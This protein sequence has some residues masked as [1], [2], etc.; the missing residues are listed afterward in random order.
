MPLSSRYK[1]TFGGKSGRSVKLTNAEVKNAW[2]FTFI[3][4][5]INIQAWKF[6]KGD[7]TNPRTREHKRQQWENRNF[8]R[9]TEHQEINGHR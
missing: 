5:V 1:K 8:D 3:N 2:S 7:T 6:I 9:G 4:I